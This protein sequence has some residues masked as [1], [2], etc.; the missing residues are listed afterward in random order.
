M[1]KIYSLVLIA[2]ALLVGTN[3]WAAVRTG[4][5]T[6]QNDN[7][8]ASLK[9]GDSTMFGSINNVFKAVKV[10]ETARI[11]LLKDIVEPTKAIAIYSNLD[12]S[13]DPKEITLDMN[14][15]TLRYSGENGTNTIH[16]LFLILKGHLTVTNSAQ[17][18]ALIQTTYQLA[19]G[20]A[21]FPFLLFG[22]HDRDSS[23]YSNLTIEQGVRVKGIYAGI[24]V[25]G[26]SS[27]EAANGVNALLADING[28]TTTYTA[29]VSTHEAY[30]V[31][32][33]VN[34][35]VE[36][37]LYGVQ[38]S[39]SISASPLTN[40]GT[41]SDYPYPHVEIGANATIIAADEPKSWFVNYNQG[42]AKQPVGVYASGY[43][44]WKIYGHVYGANAIVAK[45]GDI[46]VG[47]DAVV[48]ATAEYTE[49]N[50]ASQ[51]NESG[52]R[53]AGNAVTLL[54]DWVYGT[55]SVTFE[56]SPTITA[57][58]NGGTAVLD[59][60]VNENTDN[61]ITNITI[62]G[63][64]FEGS[65]TGAAVSISDSFEG[66]LDVTGGTYE[67]NIET[68]INQVGENNVIQ[69][70][71]EDDGSGHATIV[72]GQKDAND[73]LINTDTEDAIDDFAFEADM[74]ND[75][76]KLDAQVKPI[77]K[78]LGDLT[79]VTVKYLSLTGKNADTLSV[80]TV[81]S[82]KTLEVGQIV[83]NAYGRLIVEAG[84]K[85]IVT[86]ANGI[87]ADDVNNLVLEAVE[88]NQSIFLF[89]PDVKTNHHPH[90]TVE[91]VSK[92]RTVGG[93]T[94]W[95]RF[96]IPDYTGMK[97]TDIERVNPTA[98]KYIDPQDDE[99]KDMPLGEDMVPFI[100]YSMATAQATKD[101]YK[102]KCELVGNVNFKLPFEDNS[103]NYFANSYTGRMD[104]AE[105]FDCLDA[106]AGRDRSAYVYQPENNWWDIVNLGNLEEGKAAQTVLD[107]MQA[108]IIKNN[109]VAANDSVN[110]RNVVWIP[111]TTP[112]PAPAR[113]M[114]SNLTK[115]VVTIMDENGK[116]SNVT[117]RQSNRFSD[118]YDNGY[119]TEILMN[120][121]S[122]N[123][124]AS[125]EF[126]NMA[127]VATNNIVGATLTIATQD[128]T[129]FTMTF[130]DI[131]GL[132]LAI[133]D[134]LTGT[135]TMMNE[136][137][138]YYFTTSANDICERFDIIEPQQMP[139]DVEVVENGNEVN[140]SI[141]SVMGQYMGEDWNSLPKGI[142]IVNGNKVVK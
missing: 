41:S 3:A 83:M 13:G 54:S 62:S 79:H 98:Y 118:E 80:V 132:Q 18:R 74:S 75:I 96:G 85:L 78:N 94:Y 42:R 31:N 29:P 70:V 10:G 8:D 104:I 114:D 138:V 88:G 72:I 117:L 52:V 91:L 19:P 139:T 86:G 77:S 24:Q 121:N 92:G 68:L 87:F 20:V 60:K 133:R 57:T 137:A 58:A 26:Y 119:D 12:G 125:T 103:W 23:N 48:Q 141:Y 81:G 45:M 9:V 116:K 4:L 7:D 32:I 5:T 64:T 71:V 14:G 28:A 53:G 135:I 46:T 2:A 100:M 16:C 35:S 122:F 67:G 134:R 38:I 50:S 43:G 142:Y 21:S 111:A 49:E 90:A 66:Q 56:G 110:Y 34:D 136:S 36:A 55:M 73:D 11:T 128:E 30:G 61:Q 126:G 17:K 140:S 22:A 107:P 44:V 40:N 33:N 39:G 120:P 102:F 63:G 99:W 15:K 127:H 84:G 1:R 25:N 129:M 69:T 59:S 105:L 37:E 97:R 95:Q 47:G 123:V 112:A 131:C 113:V 82:G 106:A 6:S 89:N 65:L 76:V 109:G 93:H 51:T 115:A 101:T 108:F 27:W 124:Y 130:S